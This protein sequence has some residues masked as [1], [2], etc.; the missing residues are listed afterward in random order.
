ME[1]FVQNLGKYNEGELVG[2]W[3]KLPKT[4][5]KIKRYLKEVVKL[6]EEYEEYMIGD[7][8]IDI[9]FEISEYS[10]IYELNLLAV[11]LEKVEN[12]EAINSYI[13]IE[14]SLSIKKI[15]NLFLQQEEIPYYQYDFRNIEYCS[16]LSKEEKYGYTKAELSGLDQIL[17]KEKIEQFFNYKEYGK[18]DTIV[19]DV[20]LFE[21]GYM[22]S[23]DA[24]IDLDKYSFKEIKEILEVDKLKSEKLK[25]LYKEIGKDPVVMEIENTLEAKQKLVKGLIEVVPYKDD[26]L[27][28]CNEEGKI[29]NMK[30]N[31]VFDNDYIAGDFLVVGDDYEN[32]D[33]KNLTEEQI[34]VAKEDLKSR[35]AQYDETELE[36][37][38]EDDMEM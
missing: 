24:N 31:C 25:V 23:L 34:K 2:D 10:N 30:A 13:E 35:S 5:E 19:G 18:E 9:D 4:N 29:Y 20:E 7:Y 36:E 21:N 22:S 26:M 28:I 1:I 15:I 32:A 16:N 6:D 37:I 14:G 12:I 38:F 17:E 33:F 11:A 8:I 3:I 27:L